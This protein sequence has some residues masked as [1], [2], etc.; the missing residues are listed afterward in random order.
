M[1][2][3][4]SF[5]AKLQKLIKEINNDVLDSQSLKLKVVFNRKTQIGSNVTICKLQTPLLNEGN[6]KK[7]L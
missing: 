2:E 4:T 7:F 3:V 6:I 1:V 5:F